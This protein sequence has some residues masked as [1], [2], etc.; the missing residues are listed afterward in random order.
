MNDAAPA[1]DPQRRTVF[2]PEQVHRTAWVAPGAVV[3]GDV[4]LEAQAS[5]WYG[6]VLRGDSEAIRIGPGTNVQDLCVVHA[7]PGFPCTL[8][9]EVTVGHAAVVHGCTIEDEVVIGMR[10]VVMNGARI[11]R[12][13]LVG[14]GAVV[15]EGVEIPEGSLELGLPG[16]V[17]R[18]LSAAEQAGSRLIAAHYVARAALFAGR[19]PGAE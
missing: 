12:G 17:V 8:G 18:P 19:A 4:T 3:L 14:V 6:A 7:D 15:T 13:S 11:G 10:A 16:R 9:A 2:R 1:H 5:V